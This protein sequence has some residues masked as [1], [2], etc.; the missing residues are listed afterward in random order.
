MTRKTARKKRLL[1]ARP[2]SHQSTA[3]VG[4]PWV[5]VGALVATTAVTGLRPSPVAAHEL[6]PRQSD[7]PSGLT[8]TTGRSSAGRLGHRLHRP[9]FEDEDGQTVST[10]R[11]EIAAG[12][13]ADV[14]A[15]FERASGVHLTLSIS[16]I[17]AI[18]SPGVSGTFDIEQALQALLSGT[19]VRFRLTSPSTAVLDRAS[20]AADVEVTGR[21]PGAVVSS[22][23]YTV[24]LRDV[25]QTVEVVSGVVM[26]QQGSTTLSEALRNVPGITLQAGEGGGAS[27]TTG[28]MFNLRGFSANN[29]LFVDGVRN[30]GLIARDVFNVE[31]VDVFL[32]PTG[33]DIG[34]ATA[35]GYVNMEKKMPHVGAD[36]SLQYGYGSADQNRLQFDL[37]QP[38]ALGEPGTWLGASSLRLNGVWQ[39]SGVPGRDLVNLTTKG[40]APSLALGLGK[41]T[42]VFVSEET[43]RQRNLPDYGLPGAAWQESAL[44]AA[45][46]PVSQ[47]VG[48]KSYYGNVTDFDHGS[49]DNVTARVEHDH[50]GRATLRNQTVY[51][52]AHREAVI[53]SVQNPAAYTPATNMVALSR[54]GNDQTN[55][56]LSNQTSLIDRFTTGAVRHAVS[57][58]LEFTSEHFDT[59]TLGGL[60]TVAPVSI[61]APDPTAAPITGYAVAET[62]ASSNA[63]TSTIA[64]YAFDT[65][66]LTSRWQVNGG[67]RWE[68][69][70][71]TFR[72]VAVGGALTTD[73]Q[74]QDG[75]LSGKAALLYRFN[76]TGNVY[77]SY[78]TTA[79]PPGTANFTLSSAVNNQNNPNVKP[80]QSANFEVGSKWDIADGRA[81]FTGAVFHTINKNVLFT[82]D[83]AAIPP[84]YNQ[85]DSQT[86]NG[87]TLGAAGQV[88]KPWQILAN[89]SYLN[90]TIQSQGANDSHHLTL[91]PKW[92]GS[93]WTTYQLPKRVL[94]GGG[95]RA[96]ADVFID[97]ANTIRQPGYHVVDG[98][99]EYAVS[100]HLTM[101]VNLRNLTN[102]VYIISV[103]NNGGRYNPGNARAAQVTSVIKF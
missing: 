30:D 6:A 65:V 75:L 53:T 96:A 34:R 80:Q 36:Y 44:T 45:T 59:P 5:T 7:A 1:A 82:V 37:N 24:P 60:G 9:E 66:D 56:I 98:L 102:E 28:D 88:M 15:A 33:S 90:G 74:A 81:S 103:N 101:R 35:G 54:Q 58:G 43:L 38:L 32:G 99:A 55:S 10:R 4:S 50:N 26:D 83:A 86:V 84:V 76:K 2:H 20:Y 93:L 17:G 71:T 46:V 85:A 79:T 8:G 95:V 52:R 72:A 78:G 29:S 40:I 69:Y 47:A 49:Q 31:Q 67:L 14:A 51:N 27:R 61:C 57:T 42:R 11:Y 39:D 18:Q 63:K 100:P 19:G 16:T 13:L 22:P 25:P 89:I 87:V 48:Q 12:L 41:P 97:I 73:E 91:T 92:S 77:F 23:K 68:H 70:E 64:L 3:R 21:A 94:V 62:G